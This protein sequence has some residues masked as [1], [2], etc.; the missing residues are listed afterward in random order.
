MFVFAVPCID[1]PLD[2]ITGRLDSC[3]VFLVG[4]RIHDSMPTQ[5]W[6]GSGT[7]AMN[8]LILRFLYFA[9]DRLFL[10]AGDGNV[11]TRTKSSSSEGGQTRD[12]I[13]GPE[14]CE[15]HRVEDVM[16]DETW[17]FGSLV[18]RLH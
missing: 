8:T 15:V 9:G 7:F 2:L 17:L 11:R 14:V 6:G 5:R 4:I 12:R 10:N 16:P 18:D 3:I 13:R 1:L